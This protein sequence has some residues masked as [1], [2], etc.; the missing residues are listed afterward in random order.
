M[1]S[2]AKDLDLVQRQRRNLSVISVVPRWV[3][4]RQVQRSSEEREKKRE[5]MEIKILNPSG[6]REKEGKYGDK[7]AKPHLNSGDIES[8]SKSA[9]H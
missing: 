8:N 7:N 4:L 6:E 3:F 2:S 5:N 9:P 1:L